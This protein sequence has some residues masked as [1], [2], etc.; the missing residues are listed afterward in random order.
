MEQELFPARAVMA[1]MSRR[2][3]IILNKIHWPF[4]D[5]AISIDDLDVGVALFGV[6]P[7]GRPVARMGIYRYVGEALTFCHV[8]NLDAQTGVPIVKKRE[9]GGRTVRTLLE[10]DRAMI[11]WIKAPLFSEA[12]PAG[13]YRW[14][15]DPPVP[16]AQTD[17]DEQR[18]LRG[19]AEH[20]PK[21]DFF[22]AERTM[23]ASTEMVDRYAAYVG[24]STGFIQPAIY[25][26]VSYQAVHGLIGR[27]P[28]LAMVSVPQ[29][30]FRF[31]ALQRLISG[32]RS[33]DGSAPELR[34]GFLSVFNLIDRMVSS[35]ANISLMNS[36]VNRAVASLKQSIGEHLTRQNLPEDVLVRCQG[37]AFGALDCIGIFM[38]DRDA[39][40]NI[41]VGSLGATDPES[42]EVAKKIV[43][44]NPM[45]LMAR[46]DAPIQVLDE[47]MTTG[48]FPVSGSEFFQ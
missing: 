25:P 14:T 18:R 2:Q 10:A 21:R 9:V 4:M 11:N 13:I 16:L 7:S 15:D 30:D 3:G 19:L 43:G 47:Y 41:T 26:L 28:G 35:K 38:R 31:M 6:T 32:L 20:T 46:S 8:I 23:E 39:N 37:K 34:A 27:Q 45:F 33:Q 22:A 36:T 42:F 44:A 5:G 17:V 24:E 12:M 29:K 1:L 40:G 48:E